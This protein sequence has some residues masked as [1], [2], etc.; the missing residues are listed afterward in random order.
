MFIPAYVT[1]FGDD[2]EVLVNLS[3]ISFIEPNS[4]TS[5]TIHFLNETRAT[6]GPIQSTNITTTKESINLVLKMAGFP[7]MIR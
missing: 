5:C 3:N 4:S 2:K 7:Q 1:R 6:P